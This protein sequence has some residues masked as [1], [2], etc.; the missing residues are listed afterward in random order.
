[1]TKPAGNL[2]RMVNMP[3]FPGSPDRTAILVPDGRPGGA[4]AHFKSAMFICA[5]AEEA[6]I[7]TRPARSNIFISLSFVD[8]VI[9][10]PHGEALRPRRAGDWYHISGLL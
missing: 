1:M 3:A 4:A 8:A 7:A 2:S 9:V 5:C 10:G 6:A